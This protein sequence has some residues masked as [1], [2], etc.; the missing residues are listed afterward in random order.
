MH[1]ESEL[2]AF[3]TCDDILTSFRQLRA[4]KQKPCREAFDLYYKFANTRYEL[5]EHCKRREDAANA[6]LRMPKKDADDYDRALQAIDEA[7][8][9]ESQALL[10]HLNFDLLPTPWDN[11]NWDG[12]RKPPKLS[13][14][15]EPLLEPLKAWRM[16][17][18]AVVIDRSQRARERVFRK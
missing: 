15:C 13:K 9:F 1:A 12:P 6:P 2:L 5:T 7:E 18:R 8:K 17:A 11:E 10:K 3:K 14:D 4:P 16:K